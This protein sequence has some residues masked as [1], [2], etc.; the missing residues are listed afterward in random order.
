M[1]I[2]GK[3]CGF[4]LVQPDSVV[5]AKTGI[6]DMEDFFIM[7]RYRR[8]GLGTELARQVWQKHPGQWE[9]RVLDGNTSA[10]RFW[11]A[12]ATEQCKKTVTPGKAIVKGKQWHV[13]SFDVQKHA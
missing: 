7:R 8:R 1:T 9:I 13:L 4:A 10:L 12:A 3:Y 2:R 6:W 11:S 5:S